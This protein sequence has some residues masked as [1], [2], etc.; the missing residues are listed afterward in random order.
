M[1]KTTVNDSALIE[2]AANGSSRAILLICEKYEGIYFSILRRMLLSNRRLYNDA[3]DDKFMF[4]F[5]LTKDYEKSKG[6]F[7][8]YVYNMTV[9]KCL[10]MIKENAVQNKRLK[11]I[12]QGICNEFPK[13]QVDSSAL[14]SELS[15]FDERTKYIFNRRFF[16][17]NKKPC[18]FQQIGKEINLS[19]EGVRLIYKNH[20][21]ILKKRIKKYEDY[22]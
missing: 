20:L 9:W 13:K 14:L 18:S 8:T 12:N 22:R 6:A 3:A 15:K 7:S 21:K 16:S 2:A 10:K 5:E 1:K 11:L 4:F 19:Y 17:G